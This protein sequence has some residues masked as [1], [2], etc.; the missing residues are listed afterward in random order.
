MANTT[1][2]S[3]AIL[4]ALKNHV[5]SSKEHDY[6]I[7]ELVEKIEIYHAELLAQNEEL[8][9]SSNELKKSE[10]VLDILFARAPIPYIVVDNSLKILKV[11][12]KAQDSIGFYHLSGKTFLIKY[13]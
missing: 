13:F 9:E 6:S 5:S 1:Y 11:N 3:E 4:E 12:H 7:A 10:S 8:E 2:T